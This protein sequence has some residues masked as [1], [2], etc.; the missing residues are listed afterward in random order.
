[1]EDEVGPADRPRPRWSEG[2]VHVVQGTFDLRVQYDVHAETR[3][4]VYML[5]GVKKTDT[6]SNVRKRLI[7]EDTGVR[8]FLTTIPEGERQP[9][10]VKF[11]LRLADD[12]TALAD[13]KRVFDEVSR[14]E[15]SSGV[16]VVSEREGSGPLRL[17]LSARQTFDPRAY[18]DHESSFRALA[19]PNSVWRG[20]DTGEGG[21]LVAWHKSV[22]MVCELIDN[23]LT[24]VIANHEVN[25][26]RDPVIR[27]YCLDEAF[28]IW[29]TGR[30]MDMQ[31]LR[32][33]LVFHKDPTTHGEG[34][35][36][37]S[38]LDGNLSRFG[39]GFQSAVFSMGSVICGWFF[40]YV[41]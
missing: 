3:A 22:A 27:L 19:G 10:E 2:S 16:Y 23:S 18:F 7:E 12:R 28:A 40:S 17:Q 4:K 15:F 35:G 6:V 1:M 41:F 25:K 26:T 39:V 9:H 24:A 33:L 36:I 34:T 32:D 13:E 14:T 20:H 8:T 5:R 38:T 11:V 37:S 31:K 29:D 30:G 21:G